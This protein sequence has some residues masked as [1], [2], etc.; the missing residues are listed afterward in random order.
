MTVYYTV[1]YTFAD[2]AW[3][4]INNFD[5]QMDLNEDG[6]MQI[7]ES[8]EVNFSE[9]R[10]GIYRDI[11]LGM[12]W[13]YL[14]IENITSNNNINTISNKNDL[15]S[16][17]LG[18]P[19]TTVIGTKIYTISYTVNNAIKSFSGWDE[20]YRN[21]I[22]G[23]WD[24]TINRATWT[25]N[26]PKEY[27][28]YSWSSFAVWWYSGDQYTWNIEF[29]QTKPTQWRGNFDTPL[30]AKQGITIWLQFQSGYFVLPP[31]YNNYFT[32]KI[33]QNTYKEPQ[34]NPLSF[35]ITNIFS[36]LMS[37]LPFLI[38]PLVIAGIGIKNMAYIAPKK[39]KRAIVTQY[40]PPH[41]INPSYAIFLY[42]NNSYDPKI[43]TSLLYYRATHGWVNIQKTSTEKKSFFSSKES[44]YSIVETNLRPANTQEIDDIL[45]QQFF[46]NYDSNF[47]TIPLSESS[48][49]KIK[50]IVATLANHFKEQ[51]LTQTKSGFLGK[52]G[53]KEL[54]SEW[55]DIY[56]H[57]QGYKEYLSKVEQPVIE[58]ELKDD[59]DFINKILPRAVLFGV[60]TRILK[61]VEEVLK[62]V[63]R[64]QS[65][66]GSYLTAHTISTMNKSFSNFSV[67]PESSRSSGF[68]W[69]WGGWFS[70][71]G[72]GGWG[73]GSW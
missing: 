25:I 12:S 13:D 47:D 58:S 16:I 48:H 44:K 43:F 36:G 46:W 69:G 28:Q 66:D 32:D 56:D 19:N 60:E 73:W 65:T 24:T 21:I 59:P 42:C 52:F 71:G 6:S 35:L 22:W 30:Q 34:V 64:Y 41:Q 40:E 11:P 10:H 68:S 63:Q 54:N 38:I 49:T 5:I 1:W 70:G 18:D 14:T 53:A 33:T 45:L 61:M 57:L 8:I 7:E 2:L 29:L 4:T 17:Q 26:L 72:W 20:L 23:Q 62:K 3:Y 15:L 55:L 37:F 39:G 27:K 67:P 9:A 51:N 31:Q 50:S